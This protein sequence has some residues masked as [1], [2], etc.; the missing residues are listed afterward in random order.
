MPELLNSLAQRFDIRPGEGRSLA[1]SA[2]GAFLMM[3]FL[4]LA[5][6]LREA[7]YLTQFA[8][9]T[10]PYITAAVVVCSVPAVGAF[11]RLLGHYPA[12]RVLRMVILII[13]AGIA[14]LGLGWVMLPPHRVMLVMF[15]LWTAV[16]TLLIT[17]GFWILVGE[18]YGIRGA[19]RLYGLIGAGGTL[20]ALTMGITLNWFTQRWDLIWLIPELVLLLLLVLGCMTRLTGVGKPRA[21][22]TRTPLRHTLNLVWGERHLRL[23]ALIIFATTAAATLVDFQFKE[24]ARAAYTD[25]KDLAG[26]LGGFY[27]WMGGVAL[28]IQITISAR[29][30]GTLG[31]TRSLMVLPSLLLL[32]SIGFLVAPGLASAMFVRGTDDSL[33]KSLHRQL[34]EL[35]YVPISPELRRRTKTFIDSV[36]DSTAEG[37]GALLIFLC[38]TLAGWPSRVL[39][40]GVIVLATIFIL[41]NRGMGRAYFHTIVRR[42]RQGEEDVE[43]LV[44]SANL[45]ERRLLD[46]TFTHM[47]IETVRAS[48]GVGLAIPAHRK[49]AATKPPA[50]HDPIRDLKSRDL[51]TARSALNA[52]GKAGQRR[53][54]N[55]AE[56]DALIRAL[57]RDDL[58]DRSLE[59]MGLLRGQ[60]LAPL[61]EVLRDENADFVLRRRIPAAL[62]CM[63]VP[64]ADDA[65]LAA[66]SAKRFEVRYRAA[67]ALSRRRRLKLPTSLGNRKAVIW[68]AIRAEVSRDRPIWELQR[69]LDDFDQFGDD[70]VTARVGLRGELSLEHTFRMLSLVL[71]PEPVRAAFHGILLHDKNLNDFALEYLE[72]VLPTDVRE[73]LWAFIGDMSEQQLA[74]DVRSL[75]RVVGDLMSTRATLF[76][77]EEERA[78]LKRLLA[79]RGNA[80]DHRE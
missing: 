75:D 62:S 11:T 5:K 33:R 2:G 32:G 52:L 80:Q 7:I 73:R 58:Y 6:A 78:A 66:L 4:L 34:M 48:L 16:G 30:I 65:L 70:L 13:A 35:L 36:V 61:I 26:F 50:A 55:K 22:T 46:A 9:E 64:E 56:R 57:V 45:H 41:L 24:M 42:L 79:E 76:A 77:G 3:A 21:A 51:T 37:F 20:G 14:L 18:H 49:P 71:E 53:E 19:K 29:I 8:I 72:H 25:D 15:Y 68:A 40:P 44:N 47:N 63:P 28:I 1:F 17:S 38:V 43:G 39:A 23:I 10:L 74:R 69:L 60:I 54:L 27:G 12:Q 31:I 59:L 67:I